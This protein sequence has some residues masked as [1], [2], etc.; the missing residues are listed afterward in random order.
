MEDQLFLNQ[1][2][3]EAQEAYRCGEVPIGAVVVH[4]GKVIA[5]A[6]NQVEQKQ[7]ATAHAEL[8]ALKQ[9]T[10]QLKSK[11]LTEATLYTT[12]EPCPMCA[13]AAYWVQIKRIVIG[14]LDP[15]RGYKKLAPDAIHPKT[16]VEIQH[17][18][19]CSTLLRTFFKELR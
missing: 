13:M 7:D 4:K 9:A 16:T 3:Q 19:T 18:P 12:L 6:H 17:N 10:Q 1:A 11:Y 2:L 14:A 5:R 15:K 8:I